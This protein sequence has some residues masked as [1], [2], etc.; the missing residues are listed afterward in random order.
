M[1]F[2]NAS[3]TGKHDRII[4][5]K[6]KRGAY[7]VTALVL[8]LAAIGPAI[9]TPTHAVASVPVAITKI[10]AAQ[11]KTTIHLMLRSGAGTNYS[12]IGSGVTGTTVTGTGRAN[13]VW[14]EVKMGA[15][16]G[17]MSSQ[18]LKKAVAAPVVSPITKIAVAQYK[19]TIHLMLRSGAG[20]NHSVLGSGVAGTTVTGT[21]R[22][23]GVWY[24]VKMGTKT[25]WM[26]SQYLKKV[27]APPAPVKT[28]PVLAAPLPTTGV[29][30]VQ[31]KTTIHLN[32]RSGP[33]SNYGI[34]DSGV[35]G[36]TVTGTGKSSGTW[37]TGIWYQVKMGAKTGWMSSEYLR[38][39]SGPNT[40]AALQAYAGSKLNNK[41]QLACLITLWNR[42]SNWNYQAYNPAYAPKSPKTP[43]YQ[44]FGIAQAAP[45]SKM[46]SAGAD[47][48]TNP[49]TQINWGLDYI[50]GR[51]G[52]SCAALTHSNL[53]NWY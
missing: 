49:R 52:T 16:T 20:T 30:A 37:A 6:T 41:A 26:S 50:K 13:G 24:E 9:Q 46:A 23:N 18:Y 17:W 32:L 31:Y 4:S 10:S 1:N 48:Q 21:G 36:T 27:V 42:E 53:K 39:S 40:V 19:T 38:A 14:Y 33:G 2:L 45:G 29:A 15:K 5:R 12:V 44:A 11:Y 47:W 25:G 22:A 43:A 8:M 3:P 7:S 35:A 51:Y 34:I 28:P